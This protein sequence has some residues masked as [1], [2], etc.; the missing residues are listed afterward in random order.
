MRIYIDESGSFA[1][2][3]GKEQALS[4]VGALVV[5]DSAHDQ[6]FEKFAR[7][8]EKW[9]GENE[10]KG[11][12]LDERQIN[13]VLSILIGKKVIHRVVAI[14]AARSE[15]EIEE[16]RR[17]QAN[18]FIRHISDKTPD[19]LRTELT[20]AHDAILS[21]KSPLFRQAF[22]VWQLIADLMPL[23]VIYYMQRLPK[24]VANFHWIV[25]AKDQS[26]TFYEEFWA[27]AIMPVVTSYSRKDDYTML[28]DGYDYS[29]CN[30]VDHDRRNENGESEIDVNRLLGDIQFVNSAENNGLQ[31]ADI[32]LSAVGRAYRGNLEQ[33]GWRKSGKLMIRG[34]EKQSTVPIYYLS[35]EREGDSRESEWKPEI[36]EVANRIEND[37][38]PLFTDDFLRKAG[39]V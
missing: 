14:D 29:H 13:E 19:W 27:S 24:E 26:R 38:K 39:S 11:S 10:Y 12:K 25:D 35:V 1:N 8:K 30:W 33:R 3:M 4:F 18:N 9:G 7:L 2:P 37:A 22:A 16:F 17:Q 5:P 20:T 23:A 15:D 34:K 32:I 6:I 21:I 36:A 31:L 28:I